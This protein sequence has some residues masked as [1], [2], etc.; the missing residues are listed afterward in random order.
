MNPTDS[1]VPKGASLPP[2][3]NPVGILELLVFYPNHFQVIEL[4]QR[5]SREGWSPPMMAR[6]QLWARDGNFSAI[7]GRRNDTL[8]QQ[9]SAAFSAQGT[10]MTAYKSS[11]GGRPFDQTDGPNFVQLYE[12]ANVTLGSHASGPPSLHQLTNG[13]VNFPVGQDAGV[14]TQALQWAQAQGNAAL[15]TYT[16]DD[17]PA[18]IAAQGFTNPADALT[19]DWDKTALARALLNVPPPQ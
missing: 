15:T 7:H 1:G 6:V 13:V 8:R 11:A 14:L 17:L 18:I 3:G 5:A 4:A 12:V 2:A 19:P 10:T 9:F 16:T